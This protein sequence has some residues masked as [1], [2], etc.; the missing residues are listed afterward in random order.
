[1]SKTYS[2]KLL[3]H[4]FQVTF[5]DPKLLWK[6]PRLI[7]LI[8]A[9][10]RTSK[11]NHIANYDGSKNYSEII[12]NTYTNFAAILPSYFTPKSALNISKIISG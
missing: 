11:I 2:K 7:K 12:P 9:T 5:L 6:F 4:L 8:I 10:N 1:M 3:L